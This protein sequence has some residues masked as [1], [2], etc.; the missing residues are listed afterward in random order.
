MSSLMGD[1]KRALRGAVLAKREALSSVLARA[2]GE[3]IQRR[4][5]ALPVYRAARSIAL[6]SPLGNEVD[7]SEIRRDALA[8]RKR[9][10]YPKVTDE[11]PGMFRVRSEADLVPG[12]YGILEPRGKQRLPRGGCN[13]LAV[14][15]PG[16]A[17]DCNGNR[18]GRGMGWYDRWLGSLGAQVPRIAL[19]YEFQVLEEVPAESGDSPVHSI[20]TEQRVV[21]CRVPHGDRGRAAGLR[22]GFN[23][24]GR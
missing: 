17:F 21:D 22:S 8:A 13:G 1:K 11:S 3:R 4:V 12:R 18:L 15:V 2:S 16:V 6:Y 23:A 14:F 24:S 19:A 20:V 10:Y 9:L 7:T 5:L